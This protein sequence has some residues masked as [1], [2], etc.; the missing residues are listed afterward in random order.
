ML[1]LTRKRDEKIII[2]NTI[3]ITVI[4]IEGNQVMLGIKAPQEVAIYREEIYREIE[5]E[6]IATASMRESTWEEIKKRM[7][8]EV[9][10]DDSQDNE[11]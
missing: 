1:C 3:E 4:K 6:N 11:S 10:E 7:R 5:E 8:K 9:K 2:G